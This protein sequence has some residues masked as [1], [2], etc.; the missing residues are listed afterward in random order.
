MSVDLIAGG[1]DLHLHSGPDLVRRRYSDVEIARRAAAAGLS[2]IVLKCHHESTV[3]RAA[4]A[5]AVGGIDV[6]GGIVLNRWYSGGVH[7]KTVRA[8]LDLGATIVWWPTVTSAAHLAHYEGRQIRSGRHERAAASICR[9]VATHAAVAATGHADRRT[10]VTLAEAASAAGAKL[11]VTH[12]DF[13]IPDLGVD[14]QA[15]L[16]ER[17]PT[18]W[19]ERCAY[20]W[21]AS[22][23]PER[24]LRRM[25]DAIEATGGAARNVLSSDL[26]QPE[27]PDYPDGFAAFA[28]AL[29]RIGV[30]E[31]AVHQ[32]VVETPRRLLGVSP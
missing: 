27:L 1:I 2:G 18:I 3:G 21:L 32:M 15:R 26:G 17:Y 9:A 23:K 7:A 5:S 19:F 14:E 20:T 6:Y 13:E 28:A 11:L 25:R 16:A 12:P 29:A 24:M 8:A 10:I 4:A 30:G 22:R 31:E